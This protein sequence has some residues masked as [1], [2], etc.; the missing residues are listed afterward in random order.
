[1]AVIKQSSW[2]REERTVTHCVSPQTSDVIG[3]TDTAVLTRDK[4]ARRDQGR[5]SGTAFP[6]KEEIRN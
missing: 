5:K 3:V 2:E 1:M 4:A 6:F